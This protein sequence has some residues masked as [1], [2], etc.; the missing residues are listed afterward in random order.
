MSSYCS[1]FWACKK[2]SSL[3]TVMNTIDPFIMMDWQTGQQFPSE[4]KSCTCV[5]LFMHQPNSHHQLIHQRKKEK[6]KWCNSSL[7]STFFSNMNDSH[8]R[9]SRKWKIV[10][11]CMLRMAYAELSLI[12]RPRNFSNQFS[13]AEY[14]FKKK[15]TWKKTENGTFSLNWDRVKTR[16]KMVGRRFHSERQNTDPQLL[17]EINKSISKRIPKN[18]SKVLLSFENNL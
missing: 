7:W 18:F 1:V 12:C 11:Y 3:G 5:S 2:L 17:Q 8:I 14:Y 13:R 10:H 9:K 6:V 16:C 15:K 4:E